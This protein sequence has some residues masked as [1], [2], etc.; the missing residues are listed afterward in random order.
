MKVTHKFI[1]FSLLTADIVDST[2]FKI[3]DKIITHYSHTIYVSNQK[4]HGSQLWL[5]LQWWLPQGRE[6]KWCDMSRTLRARQ[7]S[8]TSLQMWQL[9]K[10]MSQYDAVACE[11]DKQLTAGRCLNDHLGY[12]PEGQ[13]KMFTNN[14]AK[15]T[16]GG[17]HHLVLGLVCYPSPFTLSTLF[18]ARYDSKE[19]MFISFARRSTS[20]TKSLLRGRSI[21][22][23]SV[24][25]GSSSTEKRGSLLNHNPID[26]INKTYC[27]SP[28]I[29]AYFDRRPH[30]PE[31]LLLLEKMQQQHHHPRPHHKNHQQCVGLSSPRRQS[32][33]AA[34][35]LSM[36][37]AAAEGSRKNTAPIAVESK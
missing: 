27:L 7:L 3:T 22:L 35:K 4:V 15:S 36:L 6:G 23:G 30:L 9:F 17:R 18:P 2:D 13:L 19:I 24:D 26:S 12:A 31:I 16:F 32:C 1:T 34:T 28:C 5:L 37:G 11:G 14:L 29:S 10:L 33:F 8:Q 20:L 21:V 25:H